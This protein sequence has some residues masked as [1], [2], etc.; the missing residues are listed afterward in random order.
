MNEFIGFAAVIVS[1]FVGM[2]FNNARFGAIDTRLNRMQDEMNGKFD[3]M[4][5]ETDGKFDQMHSRMDRMQSELSGRMDRV[6]G[7]LG[8]FFREI[9]RHDAKIESIEK[10]AS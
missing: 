10:K 7:D 2:L 9:G 1:I 6:Q 4:Q 8:Q 5:S 3:R